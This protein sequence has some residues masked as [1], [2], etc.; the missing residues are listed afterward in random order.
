[1]VAGSVLPHL[2]YVFYLA[3]A[4]FMMFDGNASAMIGAEQIDRYFFNDVNISLIDRMRVGVDPTAHTVIWVYPSGASSTNNAC[5]V[6]NYAIQKW[7]H[8]ELDVSCLSQVALPGYTMDDIDGFG[9]LDALPAPLDNRF[10]AGS[11]LFPGAMDYGASL[12]NLTGPPKQAVI[13]TKET[14]FNGSRRSMLQALYPLVEGDGSQVSA[15]VFTRGRNEDIWRE[16][17]VVSENAEGWIGTR[18]AGRY[19]RVRLFIDG[20]WTHAVGIEYIAA[21][22]SLR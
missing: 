21:A 5:L 12:C 15:Q 17:P 11:K 8:G 6:Y 18:Q 20:Y 16:G 14:A 10:W 9:T 3:N 4:G 13:D 7:S 22:T 2:N 19:H 1:M